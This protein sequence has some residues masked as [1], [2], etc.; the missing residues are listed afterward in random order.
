MR[1]VGLLVVGMALLVCVGG[2]PGHAAPRSPDAIIT[3]H[4]ARVLPVKRDGGAWDVTTKQIPRVLARYADR[5]FLGGF[6]AVRILRLLP[7]KN[8]PD[9][10]VRVYSGTRRIHEGEFVQGTL[11]PQWHVA[12]PVSRDRSKQPPLRVGVFDRDVDKPDPIG[13]VVLDV[14]KLL[15][16]PGLHRLRGT[17]QLYD[18]TVHVWAPKAARKKPPVVIRVDRLTAH[19]R[20]HK[21]DGSA[22]DGLGK[23]KAP[24]AA[25]V[26]R[27][28]RKLSWPDMKLK[29]IP[30]RGTLKTSAVVRDSLGVTWP[31]GMILQG[32]R[33]A[34]DGFRIV[35]ADMDLTY[36]DPIG[37]LWVGL[38]D[39]IKA[40]EKGHL[41]VEGDELNGLQTSTLR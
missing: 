6:P 12:I 9:P 33:G 37:S 15:E 35:A 38:D 17:G 39:L 5:A 21:I 28:K 22:W 11:A 23:G 19:A 34:G 8:R 27:G 20:P 32:R 41:I 14:S 31:C 26:R 29:L 13:G 10:F 36:H 7:L 40:R 30:V 25:T 4:G 1:T 16:R 3:V 2:S 24:S 18:L